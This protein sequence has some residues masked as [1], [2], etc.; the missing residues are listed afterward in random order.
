MLELTSGAIFIVCDQLFPQTI[1]RNSQEDQRP[2]W[3]KSRNLFCLGVLFLPPICQALFLAS[4]FHIS[5]SRYL[6]ALG[7]LG[8]VLLNSGIYLL[9]SLGLFLRNQVVKRLGMVW[10]GVITS[11]S[12]RWGLIETHSAYLDNHKVFLRVT[13]ST[14]IHFLT[15]RNGLFTRPFLS[16][17]VII[18]MTIFMPKLLEFTRWQK[19]APAFGLPL[20]LEG[21]II[22]N[23]KELIRT[24]LSSSFCDRLFGQCLPCDRP[25]EKL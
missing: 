1:P 4:C 5:S 17:W 25:F 22:F 20:P 18:C 6:G 16:I 23:T 9:L 15:A 10:T 11:S 7:L 14:A 8:N 13:S 3:S 24:F 12:L 19:L 21:I 2:I